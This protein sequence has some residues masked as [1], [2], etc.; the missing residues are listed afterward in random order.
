MEAR[1]T[2][3]GSGVPKGLV[4]VLAMC[5]AFGIALAGSAIAK[6]LSSSVSTG[7]GVA[8]PAAGTVLRQDNPANG[9]FHPAAGTVLRQD[10][11]AGSAA[12]GATVRGGRS[13]G[14]AKLDKS[15]GGS[16]VYNPGYDAGTIREGHGA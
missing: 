13:T 1:Q 9:A 7:T 11:P 4:I 12:F 3:R 6:N 14:N 15:D 10:N 2:L 16:T 5:A 8:H